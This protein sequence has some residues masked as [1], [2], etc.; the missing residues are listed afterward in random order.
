MAILSA[1]FSRYVLSFVAIATLVGAADHDAGPPPF[2]I[3]ST[4]A[5]MEQLELP[6][7]AIRQSLDRGHSD[8]KQLDGGGEYHSS[9]SYMKGKPVMMIITAAT[10][11]G[12]RK[13]HRKGAIV[14]ACGFLLDAGAFEQAIICVVEVDLAKPDKQR[15]RNNQV[16]RG[17]FQ[18]AVRKIT[19]ADEVKDA[20]RKA[21]NERGHSEAICA[22][23]GIE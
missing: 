13:E 5:A 17:T 4:G 22:E 1:T 19:K 23:L 11:D 10:E 3:P 12:V 16:T 18:A 14:Q 2:V 8:W 7:V 6:S 21:K 15:V 9:L 20:L